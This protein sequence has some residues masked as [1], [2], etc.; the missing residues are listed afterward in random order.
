MG[1]TRVR[2]ALTLCAIG[3]VSRK[4]GKV[5]MALTLREILDEEIA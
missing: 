4:S 3:S 2:R 5:I 1:G